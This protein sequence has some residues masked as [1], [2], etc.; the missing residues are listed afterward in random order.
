MRTFLGPIISSLTTA[1]VFGRFIRNI[2]TNDKYTHV[3]LS[4]IIASSSSVWFVGTSISLMVILA[5]KLRLLDLLMLISSAAGSYKKTVQSSFNAKPDYADFGLASFSYLTTNRTETRKLSV[6]NFK[7]NSHGMAD[8]EESHRYRVKRV[9]AGDQQANQYKPYNHAGIEASVFFQ[10]TQVHNRFQ[11]EIFAFVDQSQRHD[12]GQQREIQREEKEHRRIVVKLGLPISIPNQQ[13]AGRK[14]VV[15]SNGGDFFQVSGQ[16]AGSHD[17]QADT[18]GY[19]GGKQLK[20]F[21]LVLYQNRQRQTAKNKSDHGQVPF[22]FSQTITPQAER[23]K[24]R[25]LI[26]VGAFVTKIA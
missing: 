17:R 4:N 12:R 10:V 16:Q 15:P 22:E 14:A 20:K 6:D 23:A 25:S 26:V 9:M 7:T 21:I 8:D 24:A 18:Q 13:A 2:S 1:M 19:R 3:V 5:G 11:V